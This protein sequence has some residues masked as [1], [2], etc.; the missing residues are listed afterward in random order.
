LE[1]ARLDPKLLELELTESILLQ[2]EV[3]SVI[4]NEFAD[5]GVNLTVDD[6]GTGYSSLSYLKTLPIS[7]LKIDQS[8]ISGIGQN[9]SSDNEIIKAIIN[10]AHS[11]DMKVLAEGVETE[12]QLKFL[13]QEGCDLA[14]GYLFCRPNEADKIKKILD[15]KV[16]SPVQ[17]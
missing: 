9:G 4:L 7:K 15:K 17:A 3:T 8:F 11:L 10:L 16:T 13:K 12:A 5:L 2:T 14:Q 1:E 6:F